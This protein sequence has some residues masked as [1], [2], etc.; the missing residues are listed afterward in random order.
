MAPNSAGESPLIVVAGEALVDLVI[1]TG[2]GVVA[3]LGGG[4]YNTARTIG[5]LGLPV[6]FLGCVSH[7]R[8]G[9]QLA[10]A[11]AA[12]G[13]SAAAV[14]RTELPTTLAAAEL[15]ERGAATYRFYFA[16]TSAPALDA[17]P[18]A[19]AVPTAVH[20][21][22]LG[23]VLEPMATTLLGYLAGLADDTLVMIDPNCRPAVVTD[24][25]AYAARVAAACERADVVKVSDDD[26]RFLAPG[27]EPIEYA[28]SLVADGVS[29]V[30]LTAGAAGTWAITATGEQLVPT[31]PI[32]V[33]D[34]IGAGD[35]FGGGFLAYW[36][37]AG[38]TAH[39]L[40]DIDLVAEAAAA[41][42]EVSAIT[43]QRVGADPPRRA[44]LSTRWT[45]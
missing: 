9:T 21:G 41:A 43:C 12:D 35:S 31:A 16:G 3:K 37:L 1:D 5:R 4:P 11:L 33:A 30:L 29:A 28:R 42:Q 27:T 39:D 26:A 45:R 24:R 22:T 14:V 44:E 10:A 13:V 20:A 17:V 15:D 18:A 8:F 25:A 40:R 23:L 32:T 19:A 38:H 7:D 6:T 34:T 2:G 36:V